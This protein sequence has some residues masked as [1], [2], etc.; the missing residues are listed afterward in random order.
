MHIVT[1]ES[2]EHVRSPGTGVRI[3]VCHHVGAGNQTPL[4]CKSSKCFYLLSHPSSPSLQLLK[5][6]CHLVTCN[7]IELGYCSCMH[8]RAHTHTH[9]HTQPFQTSLVL[10]VSPSS[11][12]LCITLPSPVKLLP[13]P[14]SPSPPSQHLGLLLPSQELLPS[15]TV[16]FPGFRVCSQLWI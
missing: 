2:E 15:F 6:H 14:P 11:L 10:F 16:H 8:A 13:L 12:A 3:V 9:T 5:E 7:S 4:L 1:A